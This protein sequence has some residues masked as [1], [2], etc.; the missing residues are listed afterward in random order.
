MEEWK[1]RG[2]GKMAF[3]FLMICSEHF[4][5]NRGD[6]TTVVTEMTT[7]RVI[8]GN[9]SGLIKVAVLVDPELSVTSS[10]VQ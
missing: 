9:S 5:S 1:A 7:V 4:A 2:R 10:K 3:F 8:S 6:S